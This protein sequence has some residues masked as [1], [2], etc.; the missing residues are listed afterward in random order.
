MAHLDIMHTG[1]KTQI[2]FL[3]SIWITFLGFTFYFLFRVM[4]FGVGVE[5]TNDGSIV[6]CLPVVLPTK[7]FA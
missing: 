1:K 3:K 7:Y 4:C 5:T 2:E 6:V